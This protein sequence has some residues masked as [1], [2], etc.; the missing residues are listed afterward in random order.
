[1]TSPF[2]PNDLYSDV[3][4]DTFPFLS[5]IFIIAYNA[6]LQSSQ[7]YPQTLQPSGGNYVFPIANVP[8]E[9]LSSNALD[10]GGNLIVGIIGLDQDYN[11]ISEALILNGITPVVAVKQYFRINRMVVLKASNNL[12]TNIG[13]I[14]ARPVGS[15]VPLATI[16]AGHGS[17]RNGVLTASNSH[18]IRIHRYY[19]GFNIATDSGAPTSSIPSALFSARYN[20]GFPNNHWRENMFFPSGIGLNTLDLIIPTTLAP[21][22]SVEIRVHRI[23]VPVSHTVSAICYMHGL[24]EKI[25]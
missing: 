6:N 21:M 23:Q 16:P 2:L 7:T 10:S 12:N 4:Q 13:D 8:V 17:S 24:L 14:T 5:Q 9:V 18:R 25:V 22:A 3:S 15:V 19:Y 11:E 1:M 20:S